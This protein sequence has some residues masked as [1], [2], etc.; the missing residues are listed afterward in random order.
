MF[1]GSQAKALELLGTLLPRLTDRLMER[2]IYP[3]QHVER[4]SKP[5]EESALYKAGYGMHER[6]TNVGWMRKRSLYVKACKHPILTTIAAGV[7]L[8]VWSLAK[9]KD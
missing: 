8:T 3:T 2:I 4:P 9:R 5:R 6:G 1:I 7:G